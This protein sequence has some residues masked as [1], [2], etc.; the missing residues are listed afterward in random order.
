MSVLHETSE[1]VRSAAEAPSQS[2]VEGA[3]LAALL[4]LDGADAGTLLRRAS[5]EVA[6]LTAEPR[7]R[8]LL[9][10]DDANHAELVATMLARRGYSVEVAA[11]GAEGIRKAEEAPPDL[12]LLDVRMPSVDG[13]A[14]AAELRRDARTRDVPI[15]F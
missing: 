4:A 13:F 7:K 11:D 15:L 8:V 3:P 2:P 1:N 10:E 12:I 5:G 6:A 9:V 14:A